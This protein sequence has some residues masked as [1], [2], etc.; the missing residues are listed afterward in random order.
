[1]S[2]RLGGCIGQRRLL[3][4][5]GPCARPG[6][7]L[8]LEDPLTGREVAGGSH[9]MADVAAA[10][11]RAAARLEEQL[12]RAESR[13][14]RRPAAAPG[15]REGQRGSKRT[16]RGPG[17]QG[18]VA[19]AEPRNTQTAGPTAAGD[20]AGKVALRPQARRAAAGG[21][22]PAATAAA[23]AA[24]ATAA[25]AVGAGHALV[26]RSG[27]TREDRLSAMLDSLGADA[28]LCDDATAA[29]QQ[30]PGAAEQPSGEQV[31]R[32]LE[33]GGSGGGQKR[34][35]S[36]G[37]SSSSDGGDAEPATLAEALAAGPAGGGGGERAKRRRAS[38]SEPSTSEKGGRHSGGEGSE[39]DA[40]GSTDA[41]TK[42]AAE[43]E[44][45]PWWPL[46]LVLDVRTALVRQP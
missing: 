17:V 45:G 3:E 42:A 43:A 7:F 6:T 20:A 5:G 2:V 12:A 30:E 39:E 27:S 23:A 38:S 34:R 25:E 28:P 21:A 15:A 32:M 46:D 8:V 11:G 41:E 22:V 29:G 1:V 35:T 14:A 31:G 19:G 26:A 36:A 13:G 10:F 44:A 18:P 37:G 4:Q 9:R 24:P 16:A 33:P 40:R